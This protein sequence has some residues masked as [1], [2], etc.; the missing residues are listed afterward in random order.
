MNNSIRILVVVS[1]SLTSVYL[2]RA[3]SGSAPETQEN[4]VVRTNEVLLDAV[5]RDKSGRPLN[6]L[7][8]KDFEVYEDGIRQQIL[9]VRLVTRSATANKSETASIPTAK[10]QNSGST[11]FVSSLQPNSSVDVRNLGATAIVFDRLS[12]DARSRARLTALGFLAQGL[13]RTDVVGVFTIDQSLRVLQDFTSDATLL[14]HAIEGAGVESAPTSSYHDRAKEVEELW[15]ELDRLKQM[16]ADLVEILLQELKIN[17]KEGENR[18]ESD[19]QGRATNFGLLNLVNSMS[20]LPGRKTLIFFS[21][22]LSLPPTVTS[23]FRSV[24]SNANRA[25]VSIYSI[26]AAGL[27]VDS[28]LAD[29]STAIK[30][31]SKTRMEDD[32]LGEPGLDPLSQLLSHPMTRDLEMNEQLLNQDSTGGLGELARQT[33]GIFIGDDN[34]PLKRL[35]RAREDLHSYY[36]IG[37]RPADTDFNGVFRETTIKVNRPGAEVQG[38]KGYFA[39]RESYDSPVINYEV[40]GLAILGKENAPET[41]QVRS[42][43]FSFPT[44]G[45]PGLVPAFVEIPKGTINFLVDDAK[46]K[47]TADFS[48]VVLIRDQSNHVA[49]KLSA[50][51]VLTGPYEKL[52]TAIEGNI[53]FYKETDLRPGHYTLSSVVYDAITKQGSTSYG[54]VTVP[55]A[56][57]SNT[58]LSDVVFFLPSQQLS[59]TGKSAAQLFRIGSNLVYPTL[60]KPVSKSR[61]EE[62]GLFVSLYTSVKNATD[63][64]LSMEITHDGQTIVTLP[65][66]T[67]A[68]D[69]MGRIQAAKSIKLAGFQP[70]DYEFRFT[71]NQG[72]EMIK[73]TKTITVVP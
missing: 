15:K 29:V 18:V 16:S 55:R 53:L 62:L 40:P 48:V 19:R 4:V 8:A 26:D 59:D 34:D 9:A 64:K 68:P 13:D 66:E 67:P 22:G 28:T 41:S 7:T 36:V 1:V 21:E 49:R 35:R 5:V 6:N 37:Y 65:F 43:A 50:H 51:Y 71:L 14:R 63:L 20:G 24:I 46:T 73:R 39:L 10:T 31:I 27:R 30:R 38:R 61:D 11:T 47:Y 25:S 72:S 45:Q 57:E 70:G 54:V 60:G 58:R 69:D 32:N 2:C 52:A 23:T 44:P 56:E 33:G 17:M 42:A 12:P 3:Q